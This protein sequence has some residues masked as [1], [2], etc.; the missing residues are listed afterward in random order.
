MKWSERS[1]RP[2]FDFK[3]PVSVGFRKRSR[4]GKPLTLQE[5]ISIAHKL[6][7]KKERRSDLAK[8]FRVSIARIS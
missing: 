1:G 3:E 2:L 4:K 6:F 7:I 5:K 8:E